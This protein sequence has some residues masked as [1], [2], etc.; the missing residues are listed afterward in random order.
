MGYSREGDVVTLRL[1]ADDFARL[2]LCLGAATTSD[3]GWLALKI[4]NAV[5]AGRP[6]SEWRPYAIPEEAHTASREALVERIEKE[7]RKVERAMKAM[8]EART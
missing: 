4:A 3:D 2:L 8:K 5:N 7:C 6:R 1:T